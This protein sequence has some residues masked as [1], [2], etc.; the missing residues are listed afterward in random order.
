MAP[1]TILVTALMA[2][3]AAGLPSTTQQIVVDGYHELKAL[4]KHRYKQVNVQ[5]LFV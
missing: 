3:A 1:L 4:L 5:R 2:G